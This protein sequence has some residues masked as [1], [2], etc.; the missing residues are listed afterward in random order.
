M[1]KN[2]LGTNCCILN[3]E[4][5]KIEI[6]N[7]WH[8]SIQVFENNMLFTEQMGH[9]LWWRGLMFLISKWQCFLPIR[10]SCNLHSNLLSPYWR[11]RKAAVVMLCSCYPNTKSIVKGHGTD[12]NIFLIPSHFG[13]WLLRMGWFQ[14][15]ILGRKIKGCLYQEIPVSIRTCLVA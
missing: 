3:L 8:V 1:A 12:V 7:R 14:S 11:G 4:Y 13:K 15:K 9:H 2:V 5:I 6:K 10:T